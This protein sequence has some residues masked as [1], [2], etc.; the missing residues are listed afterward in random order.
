MKLSAKKIFV[1]LGSPR[2]GTSVIARGLN[3]LGIDLGTHLTPPDKLW[4]PTGFWE[5]EAIS[6]QINCGVLYALN[7]P[8]E[9]MTLVDK[10]AQL[11]L[12][13]LKKSAIALLSERMEKTAI[14]GFKDP[15]TTKII[16]FWQAVFAALSLEENYVIALRNPF[17]VALS[18]QKLRSFDIEMGLMLWLTH[19]FPA[20]YDTTHKNRLIVSYE[21]LLQNP[22]HELERVKQHFKLE[23]DKQDNLNNY[24][25]TFLKQELNHYPDKT[26]AAVKVIPLCFELYELLLKV[27]KDEIT[28][29]HT[30]FTNA[31]QAIISEFDRQYPLLQYIDSIIRRFRFH[32]K[33][34]RSL[35]RSL[36]WK[37]I[38]PLRKIDDALRVRRRKQREEKR[39]RKSL[40]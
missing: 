39:L 5:D 31:W 36:L 10:K 11:N 34:Q 6:K 33:Y 1:V 38:Y 23:V 25:E 19:L 26:H 12:T 16:P 40:V 13:D 21:A 15:R 24:V 29:A 22:Y 27:A 9:S 28:F 18:Y 3:A 37:M 7:Y 17:S 14:W 20:I 35:Q 32:E 2:S 8:W 4:N 30:E